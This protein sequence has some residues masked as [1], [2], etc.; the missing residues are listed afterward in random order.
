MLLGRS[1]LRSVIVCRIRVFACLILFLPILIPLYGQ[2]Y[3]T[4]ILTGD[5]VPDG[6]GDIKTVLNRLY[7]INNSGK[8]TFS[9]VLKN[10]ANW[11]DDIY[12]CYLFDGH[13]IS[14]IVRTGDIVVSGQPAVGSPYFSSITDL[15]DIVV[16]TGGSKPDN[17]HLFP[18][19]A[20]PFLLVKEGDV[21]SDGTGTVTFLDSPIQNKFGQIVYRAGGSDFKSTINFFDGA[22][23]QFVVRSDD[24]VPEGNGQFDFF[25]QK[26]IDQ[27]GVVFLF[28]SLHSI[29]GTDTGWGL[30]K[31]DS[32]VLSMV[33]RTGTATSNGTLRTITAQVNNLGRAVFTAGLDNTANGL[34]DDQA[35]FTIDSQGLTEIVREGELAPDGVSKYYRFAR[36]ATI[37]DNGVIA[38]PIQY[39]FTPVA[40][41]EAICLVEGT[42]ITELVRKGNTVPNGDGHFAS[43]NLT[44][45]RPSP[46]I[47][48]RNQVAFFAELDDTS[49]G[50]GIL[51]MFLTK[52]DG[53]IQEIVR[54]REFYDVNPTGSPDLREVMEIGEWA[55]TSNQHLMNNLND[56]GTV[57]FSLKFFNSP[58]PEGLFTATVDGPVVVGPTGFNVE[59]GSVN[60][61]GLPELLTSDDQR[62]VL[63]PV[64]LASRYQLAFTVDAASPTETPDS[65]E[66]S[67]ESNSFSFVGTVE[68]KI[69]VFNYDT[70]QFQT[71]DN[72][73]VTATDTVISVTLSGDLSRYVENGTGAI[74]ARISYQTS[75][76]FWVTNIVN[77]YLPFK[78]KV[79]HIF[80]TIT[81]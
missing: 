21:Q 63:N 66:F 37:N 30:Y 34:G 60:S 79:D 77:L 53:T 29:N 19:G 32:G 40:Q 36:P 17:I 65:I 59:V 43:L 56:D 78:T 62:A 1:S 12:S 22:S 35:I 16:L 10:T 68:Q 55:P 13:A 70:G 69:Q 7:H 45:S 64:F 42:T 47:N 72:R 14:K 31:F 27:S 28:C 54:E 52:P 23:I 57:V 73:V 46:I 6:N 20:A 33:A 74:Q 8:I 49:S 39:S 5:P 81:P 48:N 24:L 51:A 44:T 2:E 75:I 26:F 15:D 4:I 9:P 41:N 25:H 50:D 80:W 11:P 71:I 3:Q 67:V 76:P 18:D 38:F 61:G 58:N